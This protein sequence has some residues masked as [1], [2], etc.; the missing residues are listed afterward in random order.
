MLEKM[1]T[2]PWQASTLRG[3]MTAVL[4]P[5]FLWLSQRLLERLLG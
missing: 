1:P 3:L 5:L 4:L 2:W